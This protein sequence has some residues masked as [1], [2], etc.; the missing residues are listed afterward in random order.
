MALVELLQFLILRGE[1]TLGSCVDD[2]DDLI[3]ILFQR[4]IATLSVLDSEIV[5][6][7]HFI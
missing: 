3:G 5:N 2:E 1:T 6:C 4:Y 7:S